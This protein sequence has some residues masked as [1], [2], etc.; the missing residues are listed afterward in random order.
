[1]SQN[2]ISVRT[3]VVLP[4]VLVDMLR[5]LV[6]MGFS[7]TES[8]KY[9]IRLF[10]AQQTGGKGKVVETILPTEAKRGPGR[11]PKPPV[12]TVDV[13]EAD[14]AYGFVFDL[15][16]DQL[17]AFL[18]VAGLCVD[19]MPDPEGSPA[20]ASF[21]LR[22][23]NGARELV[24]NKHS[25]ETRALEGGDGFSQTFVGMVPAQEMLQRHMKK[26]SPEVVAA[27]R[28]YVSSITKS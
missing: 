27:L 10:Y 2:R 5:E 8:I 26:A 21:A 13:P 22:P 23:R 9:G 15:P 1:M 3:A 17:L 28:N 18:R 11:P 25:T 14:N 4:P 6:E 16:D 7:Q 24:I 20:F 19:G 12:A